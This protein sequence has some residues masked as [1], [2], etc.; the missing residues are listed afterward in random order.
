VLGFNLFPKKEIK[1]KKKIILSVLVLLTVHCLL[2]TVPCLSAVPSL[3]NYQGVLKDSLGVPQNGNFPMKFSIYDDSTGGNKLWEEIHMA[4]EVK[5]GL[6]NVLLGSS[7]DKGPIPDSVFASPNTWLEVQVSAS[8]LT[9]RRRIVS[10]GYA[11]TDGDWAIDGD[12]I[13]R[14]QGNVGVG[15]TEPG[16]RLDVMGPGGVSADVFRVFNYENGSVKALIGFDG[17]SDGYLKL[18][19]DTAEAVRI[20]ANGNSYFAYGNV[21]I[22]TTSPTAKLEVQPYDECH[23]CTAL[24][25]GNYGTDRWQYLQINVENADPPDSDCDELDEVGRMAIRGDTNT[26]FICTGSPTIGWKRLVAQPK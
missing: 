12:N 5:N 20:H 16:S 15:T 6:F 1:M 23:H 26:L 11:F 4:V 25:I 9:P 21:G 8:V 2:T 7:S 22:G 24:K 19:R 3:I 17:L 14:Q 18:Y 13:Y 10:V